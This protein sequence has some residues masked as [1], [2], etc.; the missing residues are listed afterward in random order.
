LLNGT[1][2]GPGVYPP[3]PLGVYSFT[4]VPREWK[5]S[6]GTDRY[7]RG[8]YT[9]FQRS[10]PHPALIV[11]DAPDGTATCT[12]RNRSNTPLQA[13]TLLNDQGFFEFAQG[14]AG[15]VLGAAKND[16]AERLRSAFQLCLAR[17]PRAMEQQRLA[18]LIAQQ[19]AS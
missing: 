1:I 5:V 2:G 13:L 9:F 19:R 14:L 15:R 12:R 18:D 16:D 8:M 10:A 7:R 6:T 3:Q 17:L 4:Q 11:F